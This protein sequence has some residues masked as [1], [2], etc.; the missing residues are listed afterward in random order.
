MTNAEKYKE[1]FGLLPDKESCPTECCEFC[2]AHKE[3]CLCNCKWWDEEY[4]DPKS[5]G[6]EDK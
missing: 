4:N 1:V 3:E 6:S 5:S 2:P